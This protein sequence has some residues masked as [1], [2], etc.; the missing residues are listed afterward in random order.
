MTPR[1]GLT[2]RMRRQCTGPDA[3]QEEQVVARDERH[4]EG[5]ECAADGLQGH[6]AKRPEVVP[7]RVQD[8]RGFCPKFSV[9]GL[10]EMVDQP[11][12]RASAIT[13][14]RGLRCAGMGHMKAWPHSVG[15]GGQ[16]PWSVVENRGPLCAGDIVRNAA[17]ARRRQLSREPAG[18]RERCGPAPGSGWFCLLCSSELWSYSRAS[19]DP[20][21]LDGRAR[22]ARAG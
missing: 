18:P 10:S 7:D 20:S 3:Q 19:A 14:D 15:E 1:Q 22:T 8:L 6:V 5:D 9:A 11:Q 16:Q 4:T 17:P 2:Q 21:F 13:P 12:R